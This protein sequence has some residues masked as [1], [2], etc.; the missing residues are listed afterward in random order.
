[1]IKMQSDQLL[2]D[3]VHILKCHGARHVIIC[4]GSRNAPLMQLF[5]RDDEFSCHSIVDERSAAYLAMG[6]ARELNEPVVVLTTSGTASLN[7]GPAVAEAYFQNIPLIILTADRPE[8]WPPQFSNQRVNQENLFA[9]NSK[10]YLGLPLIIERE[11]DHL[12]VIS[13]INDIL[14]KANSGAKGPVHLNIPLT[15]PL[16]KTISAEVSDACIHLQELTHIKDS[17]VS[18][19]N[20]NLLTKHLRAQDKVLIIAGVHPYTAEEE[21]LLIG[22]STH[23]NVVIIGENI[24]NLKAPYFIHQ[25]ELILGSIKEDNETLIPDLI[26]SLAGQVVSKKTRLFVQKYKDVP[27]MVFDSFPSALIGEMVLHN[28]QESEYSYLSEWKKIEETAL[29]KLDKFMVENSFCNLT[30]IGG[31]LNTLPGASVIHLGNSSTIRYSQ[32]FPQR[33][34][35]RY[36]GNRGT[37]GIDGSLSTAVG[38][39]MASDKLHIVILGDLSFV[40]DSNAMWNRNF[41]KNLKIVVLNDAGGGIFRIINGPDKMP[42]FEQFSVTDHPVALENLAKAFALSHKQVSDYKG[43]NKGLSALLNDKKDLDMLEI[44]TGE[45]ENSLI[46]K[47]FYKSLQNE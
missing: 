36:Y 10:A 6:M 3:L 14:H 23:Y 12:D 18:A 43:L 26:L 32:L 30:A 37:S 42:F 33:N 34:D 2:T 20:K 16:Y 28:K 31:V 7:L 40:Y 15:E 46:F 47:E 29:W 38:A 9:S 11:T 17:T 21:L 13:G 19:E 41:P 45:S 25:P 39:A 1:M 4:P 27:V 24:T 5:T 22:L 8:E 44:F 35:L